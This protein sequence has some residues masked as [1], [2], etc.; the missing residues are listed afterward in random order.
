MRGRRGL[1]DEQ[2]RVEK[3]T[4]LYCRSRQ[5][6][7]KCFTIKLC[8]PFC[9][10]DIGVRIL[11]TLFQAS[12]CQHSANCLLELSS[13]KLLFPAVFAARLALFRPQ[14]ILWYFWRIQCRLCN[15]KLCTKGSG[16]V[17]EE[18]IQER[19]KDF[20]RSATCPKS[21]CTT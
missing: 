1:N 10:L 20:R 3:C 21:L 4:K 18:T 5:V 19:R 12:R 6:D 13:S 9:E 8:F 2:Q 11:C 17:C 16:N 7:P 14:I 15:Q